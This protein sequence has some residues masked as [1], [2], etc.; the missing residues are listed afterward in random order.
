MVRT[1]NSN[2]ATPQFFINRKNNDSLNYVANVIPGYAVFGRVTEG[3]DVV[4][5]I[6][7]VKTT[8]R[9]GTGDVPVEQVI[10]KSAKVISGVN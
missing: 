2:S 5:P 9:M 1:N 4:D 8:T 6:A 7:A 10:V 3:M